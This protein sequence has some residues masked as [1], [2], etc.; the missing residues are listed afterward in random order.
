[1]PLTGEAKASVWPSGDNR[2]ENIGLSQWLI[3]AIF[4]GALET[5]EPAPKWYA[6]YTAPAIT[7]I[8]TAPA[9]RN[10]LRL[11]ASGTASTAVPE[12]LGGPAIA[13]CGPLPG[14]FPSP[15]PVAELLGCEDDDE[16]RPESV[17][18]RSRFRSARISD[19]D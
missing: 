9:A 18:L 5:R 1:M 4:A 10:F 19:A 13:E 15:P 6:P 2:G 16:I 14:T 11:R 3:C 7:R 17:S 12:P 8:A